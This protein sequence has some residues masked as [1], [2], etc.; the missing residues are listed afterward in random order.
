M[1]K[2]LICDKELID[3]VASA[4]KEN[5]D[6]Y[7]MCKSCG[8]VHYVKVLGNGLTEVQRTSNED[9]QETRAAMIEAAKLFAKAGVNV[10]EFKVGV[11]SEKESVEELKKE[12]LSE[13]QE[14]QLRESYNKMQDLLPEGMTYKEYKKD[15]IEFKSKLEEN[16]KEVIMDMISRTIGDIMDMSLED[17]ED[18]CD[19][20]NC[21]CEDCASHPSN[22]EEDERTIEEV[23]SNSMPMFI[24]EGTSDDGRKVI[25]DVYSEE[26]LFNAIED[27]EDEEITIDS[28]KKVNLT[29]TEITPVEILKLRIKNS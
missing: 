24:L 23:L 22:Q 13:E 26:E 1:L 3:G 5:G 25:A 15:F 17:D 19:C 21:D 2:C 9:T 14:M 27:A 8:N 4:K 29:L 6:Y 12:T 28:I 18:N 7:L 20:E 16:P 11:H 10:M